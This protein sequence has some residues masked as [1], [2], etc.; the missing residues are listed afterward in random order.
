MLYAAAAST[1]KQLW[2][3]EYGEGDA[4]GLSL[5]TNL[6][7]DFTWLHPTAWVYWQVL[8]GSS[9]G[10]IEC[11]EN[12][13]TLGNVNTKYFIMAQYSRHIRK[14]MLMLNTTGSANAVA[15]YDTHR[16]LLAIVALNKG[17]KV[18]RTFDLAAFSSLAGPAVRWVTETKAGGQRYQKHMDVS[19]DSKTK[20][21]SMEFPANS[22]MTFQVEN[23][24]I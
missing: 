7:L 18:T 3:S 9:W 12:K 10:L 17:E 16:H 1:Y 11:D 21:L 24:L 6:H 4:T 14:G 5:A 19:V 15:A 8:G 2:N 20:Q 23:V 22:V 13:Q